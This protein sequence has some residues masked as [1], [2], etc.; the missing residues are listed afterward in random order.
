[1]NASPHLD[2]LIDLPEEIKSSIPQEDGLHM[3]PA[4]A[5]RRRTIQL[6]EKTA[7]KIPMRQS[8]KRAFSG[9]VG[10][11]ASAKRAAKNLMIKVADEAP[12]CNVEESQN[13][14]EIHLQADPSNKAALNKDPGD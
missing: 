11:G 10:A 3:E 1:M 5:D 7:S 9:R 2:S 8:R 4:V 14:L 6:S 12:D 13:L